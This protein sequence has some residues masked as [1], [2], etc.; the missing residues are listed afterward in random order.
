[1]RKDEL[2]QALFRP[3][4]DLLLIRHRPRCPLCSREGLLGGA[5]STGL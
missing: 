3:G 4:G 1:V 2:A 5:V